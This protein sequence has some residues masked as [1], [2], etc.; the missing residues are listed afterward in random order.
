MVIKSGIFTVSLDFELYWGLR[1]QTTI[2]EYEANLKGV[3]IAIERMLELFDKYDIHT[4]WATVGFLFASDIEELKVLSPEQK[5]SYHNTKL[6]PYKYISDSDDLLQ[7]CHF[8]PEII[9]KICS[10]KNQEIGTHTFSHYYCL[11]KGQT[12]EEFSSDI[13]AAIETSRKNDITINSFSMEICYEMIFENSYFGFDIFYIMSCCS[14][15]IY[16][17]NSSN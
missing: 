3:K 4:T 7:Y 1:D 9:S 12:A 6:N 2:N 14:I 17:L 16:F 11:E 10:H 5:P 8:V 13:K 15:P